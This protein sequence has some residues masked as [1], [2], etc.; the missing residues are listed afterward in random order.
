MRGK[1]ESG[2]PCVEPNV[3]PD[4]AC[5]VG[6]ITSDLAP[7][8][9]GCELALT[10]VDADGDLDVVTAAALGIFVLENVGGGVLADPPVM[11]P[12]T[13]PGYTQR[14]IP[15]ELDDAPGRAYLLASPYYENVPSDPPALVVLDA[16]FTSS[17]TEMLELQGRVAGAADVD[18]DGK[19][20]VAVILG[21][22]TS[23]VALWLS[24][25]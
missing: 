19:P 10:D 16:A 23:P 20:D 18:E 25:G 12:H 3:D 17:T 9:E 5:T 14:V 11:V 24:G 4:D 8:L 1:V 21:G 6:S 22:G 13:Y 15:L 2:T 7:L